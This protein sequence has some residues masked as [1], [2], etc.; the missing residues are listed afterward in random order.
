MASAWNN[1]FVAFLS[2]RLCCK[3]IRI[4]N[5]DKD[6]SQV[7]EQ[8]PTAKG[9]QNANAIVPIVSKQHRRGNNT[10]FP[11]RQQVYGQA[12]TNKQKKHI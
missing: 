7:K 4:Y 5:Y 3:M 12:K 8:L 10:C 9:F 11:C 6:F 2:A 1:S